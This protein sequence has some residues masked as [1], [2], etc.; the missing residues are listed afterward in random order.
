MT[1]VFTAF[2]VG[3]SHVHGRLQL[4]PIF[5]VE[6]ERRQSAYKLGSDAIA[7]R[8]VTVSETSAA[9][10]V[11]ELRVKNDGD[12]AVLFFEGEQVLGA[13]QN[14]VFN[15][16]VLIPAKQEVTV[17]VSCVEQR[18]WDHTPNTTFDAAHTMA[19]VTTRSTLK[20][21]VSA[22]SLASG[23]YTSDQG[24][25]WESV[26]EVVTDTGTLAPTAA[27]EDVYRQQQAS[28]DD[29]VASLPYHADAIGLAIAVPGNVSGRLVTLDVFDSTQTAAKV[30]T[31]YIKAAAV[32]MARYHGQPVP[33]LDRSAVE[34]R[35]HGLDTVKW[36]KRKIP[37]LGKENRGTYGDSTASV[38]AHDGTVVHAS[39][40]G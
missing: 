2:R 9:G 21:T 25:V 29:Y 13:K 14:R 32:E 11:G 22:S 3:G 37:G 34:S 26:A 36:H 31:R 20:G 6:G 7:D 17:P 27:M 1:S 33:N 19:S 10:R 40:A 24:A 30:W 35:L 38:L 5:L 16:T 12:V 15:M 23:E 4:F 8:S 28:V 39:V 18:R